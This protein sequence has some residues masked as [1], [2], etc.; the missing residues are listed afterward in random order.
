ML[1][2]YVT[3][4]REIQREPARVRLSGYKSLMPKAAIAAR[5]VAAGVGASVTVDDGKK[6]YRVVGNH[7]RKMDYPIWRREE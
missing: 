2:L 3:F 6:T 7:A 4:D 5:N 1:E